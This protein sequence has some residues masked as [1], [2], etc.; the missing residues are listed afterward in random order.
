MPDEQQLKLLLNE[1]L[2]KVVEL[3]RAGKYLKLELDRLVQLWD[4]NQK[5]LN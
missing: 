1:Q 4:E 2:A 3:Y 5:P